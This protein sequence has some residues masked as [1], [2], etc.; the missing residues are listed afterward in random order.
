MCVWGGTCEHLGRLPR[1]P[2]DAAHILDAETVLQA[3]MR[4]MD[5]KGKV[6]HTTSD[7]K[8][9][10]RIFCLSMFSHRWERP[11]MEP[12]KAFP[13]AED[14]KKA[15]ALGFYSS[16]GLCPEFSQHQW[17]YYYWVDYACINQ[18]D[19]EEKCLGIAK[20]PAY[21]SCCIEQ[22]HAWCTPTPCI[23]PTRRTA[24]TV[25]HVWH[26]RLHLLPYMAGIELIYYHSSTSGY[27]RRA[28]TRLERV[29][30][31]AYT[32][33]TVAPCTSH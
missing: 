2:Q 9:E 4:Q 28:W 14:N 3:Y 19:Y 31:F 25:H 33:C 11:H 13:D 30:G 27:E 29:L 26:R 15:R 1:Y 32:W 23:S 8:A 20:L 10:R 7:G 21:I 17:D 5:G 24:E 16:A 12:S 22:G 6:E 18:D